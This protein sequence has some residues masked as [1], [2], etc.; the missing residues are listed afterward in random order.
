MADKKSTATTMCADM[1]RRVLAALSAR[2]LWA[3]I[4][5]LLHRDM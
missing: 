5:Y 2:A 3:A 4:V 1:A